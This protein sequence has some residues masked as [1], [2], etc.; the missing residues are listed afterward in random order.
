MRPAAC[1]TVDDDLREFVQSLAA[2]RQALGTLLNPQ[3]P[4]RVAKADRC[5][6]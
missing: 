3:L 1:P 2:N 6:A 5:R 4:R